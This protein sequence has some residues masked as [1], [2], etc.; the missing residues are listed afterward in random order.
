MGQKINI[1]ALLED[2]IHLK[3]LIATGSKRTVSGK[4]VSLVSKYHNKYD[5]FD[6]NNFFTLPELIVTGKCSVYVFQKAFCISI[7]H[8]G[9][10]TLTECCNIRKL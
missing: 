9:F 5:F 8:S 2:I 6:I 4:Q 1:S 10:K 3:K 7:V